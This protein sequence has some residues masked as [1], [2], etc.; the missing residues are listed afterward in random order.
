MRHLRRLETKTISALRVVSE[1]PH[2]ANR[3]AA[4]RG[5]IPAAVPQVLATVPVRCASLGDPIPAMSDLGR[6]VLVV[7]ALG[8]AVAAADWVV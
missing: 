5:S 7:D 1:P 3:I 2:L 4:H 6:V 8:L